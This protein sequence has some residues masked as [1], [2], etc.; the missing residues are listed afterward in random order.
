MQ[1][2]N[3]FV[4]DVA[5]HD[6]L[7][8]GER[9]RE[10]SIERGKMQDQTEVCSRAVDDGLIPRDPGPSAPLRVVQDTQVGD[11]DSGEMSLSRQRLDSPPDFAVSELRGAI[12]S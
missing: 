5:A 2:G 3:G 9:Q 11:A 4:D 6:V 1:C 12:I 10:A 8:I 7:R